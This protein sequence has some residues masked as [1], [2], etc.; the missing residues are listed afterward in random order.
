MRAGRGRGS[1][2]SGARLAGGLRGI[3]GARYGRPPPAEPP[4]ASRV[5]ET[6]LPSIVESEDAGEDIRNPK[7]RLRSVGIRDGPRNGAQAA[8]EPNGPEE[9]R[10]GR[11][12][13]GARTGDKLSLIHI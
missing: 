11:G 6:S 10:C 13:D 7:A 2:V 8:A 5:P 9:E 12:G 3:S 4:I 1:E